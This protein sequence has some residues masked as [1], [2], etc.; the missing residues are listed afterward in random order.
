[1]FPPRETCTI[2]ESNQIGGHKFL[3]HGT[4]VLDLGIFEVKNVTPQKW[5]SRPQKDVPS[6]ESSMMQRLILIYVCKH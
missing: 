6:R 5:E 1:M 4:L 2:L 3:K